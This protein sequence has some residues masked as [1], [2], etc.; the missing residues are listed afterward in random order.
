MTTSVSDCVTRIPPGKP[1]IYRKLI[2]VYLPDD[3]TIVRRLVIGR[4]STLA[5]RICKGLWVPHEKL[6]YSLHAGAHVNHT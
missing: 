2:T 1:L 5:R 6:P 4:H 3:S